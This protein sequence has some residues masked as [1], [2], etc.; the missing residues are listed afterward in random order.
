V[1]L[2]R[3]D[4]IMVAGSVVS[5][6]AH[7]LAE[8]IENGLA[9]SPPDQDVEIHGRQL[10]DSYL[11][12][13]IDQGVGLSVAELEQANQR[14]R[15]EGDFITAP[16]RFLG[17]Y[18]VGRLAVDMGID[19]RLTPSPVTGVTAR[20]TLPPGMLVSQQA[21][22]AAAGAGRNATPPARPGWPMP[23]ESELEETQRLRL[24]S[25]EPA[26]PVPAAGD[27]RVR[28]MSVE[29][30]VLDDSPAAPPQRLESLAPLP[31]PTDPI[32]E[33]MPDEAE[34][35]TNGLRKRSP[36]ARK[37]PAGSATLVSERPE[38]RPAPVS[39][40]AEDVR[41]RLTAFR[42]GVQ[43]GSTENAGRP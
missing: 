15:G 22:T 41:D 31:A 36:R 9:F 21:V 29:Y 1:T 30:V 5:G 18:V 8:L 35:T 23:M 7:M 32:F 3:V 40:S 20:I 43:R 24:P 28:P 42:Q 25:A 13:V 2:R 4:E 39:A 17:H 16:A 38:D 27:G 33:P 19:V 6:V 34:R 26:T 11:I 14:L 10:A 37:A 12:A